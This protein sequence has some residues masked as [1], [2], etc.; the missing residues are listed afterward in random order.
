MRSSFG[1]S[2]RVLQRF[3]GA[4]NFDREV[5]VQNLRFPSFHGE[6]SLC[7]ME[8]VGTSKFGLTASILGSATNIPLPN[9]KL[10]QYPKSII[11]HHLQQ[12]RSSARSKILP[13]YS[14]NNGHPPPLSTT[15]FYMEVWRWSWKGEIFESIS[16]SRTLA[17]SARAE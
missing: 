7:S 8:S 17:N 15:E 13:F 5:F 6:V 1:P 10:H 2:Q 16:K 3:T 12:E 9:W 14:W 11:R 4:R